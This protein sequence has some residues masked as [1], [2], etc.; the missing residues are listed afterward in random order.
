[1]DGISFGDLMA[2]LAEPWPPAASSGTPPYAPGCDWR[3]PPRA[4]SP[5]MAVSH[6]DTED[7]DPGADRAPVRPCRLA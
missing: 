2:A 5:A 7:E 3:R 1:V 4:S 6:R